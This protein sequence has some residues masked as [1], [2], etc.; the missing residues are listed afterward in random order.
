VSA[1]Q[2]PYAAAGTLLNRV[3]PGWTHLGGADS[4]VARLGDPA[5]R[6]RIRAELLAEGDGTDAA[7]GASAGGPAGVMIANVE[8]AGDWMRFEG[9]RLD[10]V[11]RQ[12]GQQTVDALLDLLLADRAATSAIFFSMSEE[13]VEFAMRQPWVSVGTD[14]GSRAADESVQEHP[15]P[16]AYGTFPRILCRYVRDREVLTLEDAVRKFTSLAAARVGLQDRGVIKA[17]LRADLTLFE[18]STVCDRATFAEPVQ[19]SVGI[20]HVVVNGVP[21]LRDGVPTGARP[22]RALRRGQ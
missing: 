8:A 21:V 3:L 12:R 20:R 18:P 19:T 13:D 1:N 16:R 11:A 2:Y 5:A 4:L 22:G 14:A 15:H 9:M 10:E 17:G 6:A 7:I